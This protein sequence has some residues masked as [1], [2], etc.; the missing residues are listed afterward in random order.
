M[1]QVNVVI[2]HGI[3]VNKPGYAK[4][5]I[6]GIEREFYSFLKTILPGKDGLRG[7]INFSEIVWDDIVGDNQEKF[8]RIFE[9]EFSRRARKSR[10]NL[11]LKVVLP[12]VLLSAAILLLIKNVVLFILLVLGLGLILWPLA[13][14]KM[15]TGFASEFF[16]DIIGYRNK[17]VY[18]KIQERI[19]CSLEKFEKESGNTELTFIAHSLGTVI[20]SD[21]LYD[22]QRKNKALSGRY[23][24]MNFFTMG[25]P[26]ALFS[27]QYGIELFKDPV[28]VAPPYGRWINIFDKDDPIA[29][30]LK[31]LNPE[32]NDA[33]FGDKEVNTGLLLAS[34]ILYWN[35]KSVHKI[36][37][38][39]LAVD[40]IRLNGFSD[41]GIDE[42][43]A[44]YDNS[45]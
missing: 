38:Q 25:S 17:E 40:W 16:G 31:P 6:A 13:K 9:E 43:Y 45:L 18:K 4:Q 11:F 2:I 33:V 37:A 34:H 12:S 27:L 3:G 26:I 30:P 35:C 14:Y 22:M 39:K 41:A 24:V 8:K 20:A 44:H 23:T 1:K 36:I 28:R 42:L 15:Q 21:F 29:Y 10:R 5:I 19:I 7:L 32:H